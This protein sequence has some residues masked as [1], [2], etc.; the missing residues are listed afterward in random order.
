MLEPETEASTESPVVSE[1]VAR[2]AAASSAEPA[3]RETLTLYGRTLDDRDKPLPGV[4]VRIQGYKIWT[5]GVE[6]PRLPGKYDMRGFELETDAEGRFR[7]EVPKPTVSPVD[8][9]IEP[10]PFHDSVRLT[11][12]GDRTDARPPITLVSADLG[13]FRLATTGAIRGRITDAAGSGLENAELHVGKEAGYTIGR[14]GTSDATGAYLIAHVPPGTHGVAVKRDGN[15]QQ[16]QKPVEVQAGQFTDG[17]DF[18][19][20]PAPSLRGVVVD[21]TGAPI[22]A[23]R[24][25]GWPMG[26]GSASVTKSLADGSFTLFLQQNEPS[27]LEASKVGFEPFQTRI[28]GLFRNRST[29][30]EPGTS[31]L[32]VEMR[33]ALSWELSVVDAATSKPIERFGFQ[34]LVNNSLHSPSFVMSGRTPPRLEQHP[35]GV[36]SVEMRP[37]IDFLV[38]S[39]TGFED[40]EIDLEPGPPPNGRISVRMTASPAVIGRLML[41]SKPASSI[42]ISL[43]GGDTLP[44]MEP[45]PIYFTPPSGAKTQKLAPRPTFAFRRTSRLFTVSD[46]EGRFRFEGVARGTYLLG[47]T[48]S[49]TSAIDH[50]PLVVKDSLLDLGDVALHPGAV[51]GGR[52]IVPTGRSVAGLVIDLDDNRAGAKATTD[53]NGRF[54]F[55]GLPAGVHKL[56]LEEVAGSIVD[57]PALEV[58]LAAGEQ[59][60]VLYDVSRSGACQVTLTIL[61]DSQPAANVDVELST[62]ALVEPPS[63]LWR[64]DGAD[65]L[66][67]FVRLGRTDANGRVNAAVPARGAARVHVRFGDGLVIEHPSVELPLEL[68]AR[69]ETLVA[70]EFGRLIVVLPDR[71]ELPQ[72]GRVS[73][74]LL[75]GAERRKAMVLHANVNEKSPSK[76]FAFER[77]LTGKH[78]LEVTLTGFEFAAEFKHTDLFQG[79]E[80]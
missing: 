30:I 72:R 53:S 61:V 47:V 43:E 17:V 3:P 65:R 29:F 40:A 24:L 52:V 7:F 21:E 1:S 26:P 60:E 50:E 11:F 68:D 34:V 55:A 14:T 18:A 36:A 16:F 77:V 5:E 78:E 23:A 33:H 71:V 63:D 62:V 39:A 4:K 13:D 59:R 12:G 51:L 56:I 42:R 35:D 70:F 28:D 45:K 25:E 38:V 44:G 80:T 41:D 54:R 9:T 19:L 66:S 15:L 48:E 58:E 2:V 27:S 57:P 20:A 31:D 75:E 69:I 73:V 8:F 76:T 74:T 6:V 32:R 46:S 79:S 67:E 22:E 49:G 64:R 10:D 37:G